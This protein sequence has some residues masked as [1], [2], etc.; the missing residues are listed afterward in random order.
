[1]KKKYQ[2]LFLVLFLILITKYVYAWESN[3]KTGCI[4]E[5]LDPCSSLDVSSGKSAENTELNLDKDKEFNDKKEIK[6]RKKKVVKKNKEKKIN[7][8]KKKIK[9]KKKIVKR[10]KKNIFN[11]LLSNKTDKNINFNKNKSFESFKTTLIEYNNNTD[12]PNI[13]N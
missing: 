7:I 12:Y 13:D 9:K 2:T 5:N 10:K 3:L 6:K 11:R 1:M 4:N 8:T